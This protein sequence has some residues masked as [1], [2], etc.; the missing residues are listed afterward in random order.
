LGLLS[1]PAYPGSYLLPFYFSFENRANA[2]SKK[3]TEVRGAS[4][5]VLSISCAVACFTQLCTI[6]G[7]PQMI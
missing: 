7:H 2:S 6:S 5:A 4:V 3:A 1:L